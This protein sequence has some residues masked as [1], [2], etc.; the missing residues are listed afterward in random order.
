MEGAPVMTDLSEYE[1][2]RL[3][4]SCL[5]EREFYVEESGQ[6]RLLLKMRAALFE[7]VRDIQTVEIRVAKPRFLDWLLGQ[8][9]VA[10][11][12]IRAWDVMVNP[13]PV[14]SAHLRRWEM[15]GAGRYVL[16]EAIRD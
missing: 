12:Q 7:T 1:K 3:I 14:K 5:V 9:I 8:S 6:D 4:E 11:V 13:P 2:K 10:Q 16:L 15:T